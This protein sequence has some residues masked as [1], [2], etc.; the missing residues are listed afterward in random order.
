MLPPRF[1]FYF[2]LCMACSFCEAPLLY[3]FKSRNIFKL[4]IFVPKV[5]IKIGVFLIGYLTGVCVNLGIDL[6]T[7]E[8]INRGLR[9]GFWGAALLGIGALL[10]DVILCLLVFLKAEL[11][12]RQWELQGLFLFVGSLLL[13][14]QGKKNLQASEMRGPSGNSSPFILCEHPIIFGFVS[15]VLSPSAPII[16]LAVKG[17]H[18]GS[19]VNQALS[20]MEFMSGFLLGGLTWVISFALVIRISRSYFDNNWREVFCRA[21]GFILMVFGI[22]LMAK[23]V[24]LVGNRIL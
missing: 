13:F 18:A 7:I 3:I 19:N 6:G 16:A 23:L 15:S 22:V 4:Y 8:T 17:I 12:L 21:S 1:G 20:L 5:G 11:L 9:K 10:G 2:I 14:W 24:L